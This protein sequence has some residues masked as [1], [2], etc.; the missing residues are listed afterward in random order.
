MNNSL[1]AY[2]LGLPSTVCRNGSYGIFKKK[3]TKSGLKDNGGAQK[4]VGWVYTSNAT[5]FN[6]QQSQ[7]ENHWLVANC[8]TWVVKLQASGNKWCAELTF[9]WATCELPLITKEMDSWTWLRGTKKFNLWWGR[10]NL[11]H[12]RSLMSFRILVIILRNILVR[13]LPYKLVCILWEFSLTFLLYFLCA[14]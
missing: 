1:H 7:E 13:I 12:Q 14:L 8:I 5:E 3:K 11:D 4:I 9:F 2:N 6:D 10:P